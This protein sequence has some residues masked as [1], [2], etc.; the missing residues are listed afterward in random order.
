VLL[1]GMLDHRPEQRLAAADVAALL[2]TSPF[3]S[4]WGGAPGAGPDFEPPPAPHDLTALAPGPTSTRLLARHDLRV[5]PRAP[6]PVRARR[7][8]RLRLGALGSLLVAVACLGALYASGLIAV[9]R[10]GT[11]STVGSGT[12]G[13]IGLPPPATT[14]PTTTT[15][16][17]S[18]RSALGALVEDVTA[19]VAEGT[20]D[21]RTGRA[22][23]DQAAQAVD[24]AASGNPDQAAGDL[25]QA[26]TT[27]AASVD[28]GATTTAEGSIVQADLETVAADLG[29]GPA[30]TP[31]TTQPVAANGHGNGHGH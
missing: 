20:L 2:G 5:A 12:S 16:I 13:P 15:T 9:P 28:G 22:V 29:L 7:R 24:D 19:G 14:S 1:R 26:A 8:R 31:A 18:G 27:L 17:P 25:Q 23:S 3:G 30:A 21:A 10:H 6:D 11:T 4:P